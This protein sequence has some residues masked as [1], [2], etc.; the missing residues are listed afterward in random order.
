MN[1]NA[2][3]RLV[4]YSI[5]TVILIGVLLT[6]LN[7]NGFDWDADSAGQ[8]VTGTAS[9]DAPSVKRI[10]IEWVDGT[11]DVRAAQQDTITFS[12]TNGEKLCMVYSF[13]GDTLVIRYS[14]ESLKLGIT[15][16][17]PDKHLTVH[18][19]QDWIADEIEISAVSADITV[20]LPE[21][22]ETEIESV[23]GDISVRYET[24]G[25]ISLTTVSGQSSFEGICKELE[26]SSVSG[27]CNVK[28]LSSAKEIRMESIS[29]DLTV[30]LLQQY[31]F[32][33]Q[34][35]SVSGHIR[36]EFSTTVSGSTHRFGDGSIKVEAETVSGNIHIKEAAPVSITD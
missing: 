13:K 35:D 34:L 28:L 30:E 8:T 1:R 4:I 22:R 21:V 24:S 17:T 5:I 10:C 33:A 9:V 6:G 15:I 11:V 23:S 32:T 3:A 18:V 16:K 25:E 12:E 20:D 2:F 19:P 31:G 29:G 27:E 36:S 26:C 14:K 7:W